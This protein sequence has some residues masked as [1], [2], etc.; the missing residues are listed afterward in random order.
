MQYFSYRP[1]RL[2]FSLRPW[3][4]L[5]FCSGC[6]T[7]THTHFLSHTFSV[8][9]VYFTFKR[10]HTHTHTHTHS[11][12]LVIQ[13]LFKD[14]KETRWHTFCNKTALKWDTSQHKAAH[15]ILFAYLCV[16]VCV[17]TATHTHTYT[18]SQ[19]Y[20]VTP[21]PSDNTHIQVIQWI[22]AHTHDTWPINILRYNT[23]LICFEGKD[24]KHDRKFRSQPMTLKRRRHQVYGKNGG[25]G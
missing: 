3:Q 18:V 20:K 13:E 19:E 14:D 22:P 7:F 23:F 6:F 25:F 24:K 1:V 8:V 4:S 21:K 9:Y 10:P 16:C 11:L 5:F 12:S 2:R 15:P 17:F